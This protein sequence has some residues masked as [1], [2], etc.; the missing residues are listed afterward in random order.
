M[1]RQKSAY[2][3]HPR[4]RRIRQRGEGRG[5]CK[6][7]CLLSRFRKGYGLGDELLLHRLDRELQL[8]MLLATLLRFASL[9]ALWILQGKA[10]KTIHGQTQRNRNWKKQI[11]HG[12]TEGSTTS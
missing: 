1:P 10:G 5:W 7:G 6:R 11:V 2:G 3:S 9:L 12:M 4:S 8:W